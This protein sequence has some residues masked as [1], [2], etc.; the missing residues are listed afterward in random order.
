VSAAL[1]HAGVEVE[2]GVAA[3]GAAAGPVLPTVP[4][5]SVSGKAWWQG[6]RKGT[7]SLLCSSSTSSSG[8]TSQPARAEQRQPGGLSVSQPS[9]ARAEPPTP[10]Q[11]RQ[12]AGKLEPLLAATTG[13][14]NEHFDF[15]PLLP[16]P[17]PPP[18]PHLARAR[19]A[20]AAAGR[21]SE[22]GSAGGCGAHARQQGH[23]PLPPLM[24]AGNPQSAGGGAM[25]AMGWAPKPP[26]P[27]LPLQQ[28][29]PELRA[30]PG[31]QPQRAKGSIWSSSASRQAALR[32]RTT[33]LPGALAAGAAGPAGQPQLPQA[34][35]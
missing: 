17:R 28:Q 25:D 9:P 19:F 13:P 5:V 2:E 14:S 8:A 1:P 12:M 16:Q 32:L 20:N 35:R 6:D 23:T 29:L 18:L 34:A 26:G 24:R 4:R 27:Q 15:R 31:Q 33:S 21:R 22:P 10:F 3:A 7:A 11:A 30:G